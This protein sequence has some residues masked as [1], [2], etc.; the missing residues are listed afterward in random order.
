MADSHWWAFK[1]LEEDSVTRS[2]QWEGSTL[3]Q[4]Q[5]SQPEAKSWFEVMFLE[6]GAKEEV[7]FFFFLFTQTL[8]ETILKN[9]SAK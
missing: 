3:S 5:K 1:R 9:K 8:T 4:Q 6:S 2:A 7:D